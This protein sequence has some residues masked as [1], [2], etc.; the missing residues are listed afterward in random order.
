ML[1]E[2]KG[3]ALVVALIVLLML[4]L[5]G[6][7]IMMVSMNEEQIIINKVGHIRSL[8]YAEAGI[9]ESIR[10]LS[11]NSSDSLCIEDPNRP[12]DPSWTTYV[13]L[14][15]NPP[16]DNP[17][18]YYRSS[19][20]TNLPDSQ[21]L[22]YTTGNLDPHNSL[23]IHHKINSNISNEIFYYNWE[24]ISEESHDP[25]TY[26]GPFSPIEVIES[27]GIAM[28][29]RRK[30]RVEV[31]RRSPS[32]NIAAALSCDCNVEITGK[33]VCCGHNHLF[34]TPRGIDAE[35]NPYE[36]FS[37][38]NSPVWHVYRPDGQ[39]HGDVANDYIKKTVDSKCSNVGC[40]PG[41]ST[42]GHKIIL[43]DL[44]DVRGNPDWTEDPSVAGFYNLY[45]IFGT[46]SWEELEM[47]YPW[48]HLDSDTIDGGN[49]EGFYKC[50]G[51]LYLSGSTSLSGILWV[52]GKIVQNG[53]FT[54]RGLIYSQSGIQFRGDVWILGAVAIE[55][56]SHETIQPFNGSG[57]LLYSYREVERV[58][59][60]GKGY[61]VISRKE[62]RNR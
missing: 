46:L 53:Q 8:V 10:R 22:N 47:I 5:L 28:N 14:S 15:S 11:L 1:M 30:V 23:I 37:T 24:N 25:A 51:D 60:Q 32:L 42:P 17:P 38:T 56:N 48:Q 21:I 49:Y 44:S 52:T 2:R 61:S 58:V 3:I 26:N 57:V 40:L 41:I 55:G 20:Q 7:A 35:I 29:A 4:T 16:A 54:A 9:S 12:Y 39:P 31:V 59:A 62:E 34:T 36:C 6:T 18:V 45:Q 43:S 27:V 19:V 13:L 50:E 33:F